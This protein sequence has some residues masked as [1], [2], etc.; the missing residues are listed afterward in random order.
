[1]PAYL[2]A[3]PRPLPGETALTKGYHR[4]HSPSAV[5]RQDRIQ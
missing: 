5:A 1:M 2:G 3:A 4:D